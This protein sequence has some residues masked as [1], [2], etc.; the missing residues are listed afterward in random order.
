MAKAAAT[1]TIAPVT[2]KPRTFDH[3]GRFV[4]V[5]IPVNAKHETWVKKALDQQF[6]PECPQTTNALKVA[7]LAQDTILYVAHPVRVRK[8]V[9][10]RT[11]KEVWKKVLELHLSRPVDIQ[12]ECTDAPRRGARIIDF[13]KIVQVLTTVTKNDPAGW[14]F[15]PYLSGFNKADFTDATIQLMNR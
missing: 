14:F 5:L 8:K 15:C 6:G 9:K 4:S 12:A 3:G 7:E 2:E 1:D 11:G 13:N 10:D